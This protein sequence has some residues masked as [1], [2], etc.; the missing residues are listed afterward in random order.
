M[1]QPNP[2]PPPPAAPQPSKEGVGPVVGIIVILLI[3]AVG[4]LYYFFSQ[5]TVP[6]QGA[7]GLPTAEEVAASTD[8][9]VQASLTQGTS[10]ALP[11]IEADLNAT[12]LG[13]VDAAINGL[14]EQ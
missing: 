3:L 5:P 2:V 14:S 9:D 12:N 10:D 11:A 13:A 7:A 8:P 6:G 4:G 1:D